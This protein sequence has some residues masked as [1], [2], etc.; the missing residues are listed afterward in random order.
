MSSHSEMCTVALPL[1]D[2]RHVCRDVVAAM[3]WQLVDETSNQLRCAE[4]ARAI[5]PQPFRITIEIHLQEVSLARTRIAVTGS[6]IGRSTA[7][8]VQLRSRV[9]RLR[10]QL[11]SAALMAEGRA[12]NAVARRRVRFGF[13]GT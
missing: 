6:N 4:P 1:D 5:V 8:A 7:Q 2:A 10:D 9:R 12:Y 3:S 11:E 13:K